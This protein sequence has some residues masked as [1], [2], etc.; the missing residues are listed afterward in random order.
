MRSPAGTEETHYLTGESISPQ[1]RKSKMKSRILNIAIALA[2]GASLFATP[3]SAACTNYSLPSVYS[4]V[5]YNA[6]GSRHV[7]TWMWDGDISNVGGIALYNT[8]GQVLQVTNVPY[9]NFDIPANAG[10]RYTVIKDVN[11]C[12][13]F[14][15]WRK[16]VNY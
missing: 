16:G 4:Q 13:G 6:N 2:I 14:V 15:A 8:S 12:G 5:T 9:M 1:K 3:A 10:N 7:T 11:S